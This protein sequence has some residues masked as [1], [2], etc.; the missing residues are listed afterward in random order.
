M[1]VIENDIYNR[2]VNITEK[3]LYD[4][5]EKALKF[6]SKE[7]K[8]CYMA[9]GK[10][11]KLVA[12]NIHQLE[13]ID[14]IDYYVKGKEISEF[15]KRRRKYKKINEVIVEVDRILHCYYDFDLHSRK[16]FKSIEMIVKEIRENVLDIEEIQQKRN[17]TLKF[18]DN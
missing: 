9:I 11:D 2:I 18:E 8:C 10:Y 17:Y 7:Y 6:L 15:R 12:D 1:K 14:D 5:F 3:Y 16:D 13:F 4:S